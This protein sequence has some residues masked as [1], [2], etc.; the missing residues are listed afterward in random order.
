MAEC[1]V[2]ARTC[3]HTHA[4]AC[5]LTNFLDKSI[6]LTNQARTLTCTH[7][8]YKVITK[9]KLSRWFVSCQIFKGLCYTAGLMIMASHQTFPGQIKHMSGEIKFGQTTTTLSMEILWSLLK[10]NVRTIFSPYHKQ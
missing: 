6:L 2:H 1:C 9:Y 4:H 5:T 8:V 7:L 10:M 3:V